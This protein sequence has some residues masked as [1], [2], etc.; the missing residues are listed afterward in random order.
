MFRA[1][2]GARLRADITA[3]VIAASPHVNGKSLPPDF[4]KSIETIWSFRFS[5]QYQP[6]NATKTAAPTIEPARSRR[7]SFQILNAR[8][9]AT[10][11]RSDK[12][13]GTLSRASGSSSF[14]NCHSSAAAL[15]E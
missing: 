15:D 7:E 12:G 14:I 4:P 6:S 3:T 9:A 11:R 1:K 5:Q 2:A 13:A 8:K 10:L